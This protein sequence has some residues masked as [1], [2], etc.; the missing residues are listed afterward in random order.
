MTIF[1]ESAGGW[2]VSYHLLSPLSSGLFNKAIVQSGSVYNEMVYR[3]KE[4]NL[5]Q[6]KAFAKSLGCTDCT[7]QWMNCLKKIQPEKLANYSYDIN[8]FHDTTNFLPVV[9][10]AFF[11]EKPHQAVKQGKF[12]SKVK[13]LAGVTKDEGSSFVYEGLNYLMSNSSQKFKE[14]IIN[15]FYNEMKRWN[16]LES[17]E[18]RKMVLN[19]YLSNE[20]EIDKMKN[21][22]GHIVGDY[23]LVCPTYYTAKDVMLWSGDNTVYFYELTHKLPKSVKCIFSNDSWMGICHTEDIQFV[24]GEPLRF[25]DKHNIKDQQFSLLIMNLWSNFAKTG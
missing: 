24:F 13:I 17:P 16:Y 23:F 8:R 6:S 1:G 25:K 22:V 18:H 11:P 20:T 5:K 9:G 2:S 3:T 14:N 15:F 10:E 4:E 19:Y 7:D 21:K 12:N